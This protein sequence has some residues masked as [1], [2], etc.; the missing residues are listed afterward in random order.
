MM[1]LSGSFNYETRGRREKGS[2]TTDHTDSTDRRNKRRARSALMFKIGIDM[3]LVKRRFTRGSGDARLRK[4]FA[5]ARGERRNENRSSLPNLYPMDSLS[6]IRYPLFFIAGFY[7][8]VC[9]I[10]GD[11]RAEIS[12]KCNRSPSMLFS[13][14]GRSKNQMT[15]SRKNNVRSFEG[16]R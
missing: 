8:I 9:P 4:A 16:S 12:R 3:R 2:L 6:A 15:I 10:F 13:R 1:I 7:E 14:D 11:C 5:V